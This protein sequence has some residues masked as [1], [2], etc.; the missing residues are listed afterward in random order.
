[1][2]WM[3]NLPLDLM[4]NEVTLNCLIPDVSVTWVRAYTAEHTP[5]A[6]MATID[7]S[8]NYLINSS[9]EG[10]KVPTFTFEAENAYLGDSRSVNAGQSLIERDIYENTERL[11]SGNT[12]VGNFGVEGNR[13]VWNF[14]SSEDTVA[15]ITLLLASA[16]Y[17]NEIHGNVATE[18]IG[19]Y[20]RIYV[21]GTAVNL[22][23]VD[24]PVDSI[25]NYYF[26][27]ALAIKNVALKEGAN[28]VVLEVMS[29]PA[30][31]IDAM[32]IYGEESV[33]FSMQNGENDGIT[34]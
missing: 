27:Q 34:E 15:D 9:Q 3:E 8:Y 6:L 7:E 33:V 2:V 11:A 25:A 31:N 30:P 26:W 13:I 18:N 19:R 24:L 4:T 20:I 28:E 12:S 23:G 29:Y 32:Y 21:N 14:T 10:A 16:N 22:D 1:D 17:S 5:A